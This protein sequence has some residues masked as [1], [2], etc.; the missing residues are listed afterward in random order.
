MVRSSPAGRNPAPR[1]R[2]VVLAALALPGAAAAAPGEGLRMAYFDRYPPLSHLGASGRMEGLLIDLVDAVGARAGLHFSHHG[3]P[4]ARA[5]AMVERGELD[6]LCTN[7]TPARKVYAWF[8]DTP[9]LVVT[10]GLFFR[11]DDPRPRE[12][13]S[14]AEM[15][16]LR[17]GSYRGSGFAQQ[18]LEP[19]RIAFDHDAESVL[20]RIALGDLD[21]YVADDLVTLPQIR[22]LG[23]ATKLDYRPLSFLPPSQYRWGLRKSYPEADVLV[24]RMEAAA[25]QAERDGE[26]RALV[27]RQG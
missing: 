13:R 21:I 17:Q 12:L 22:R 19:E 5:Q 1:R 27:A 9:L 3:Y 11:A 14:V 23:L 24:Q 2:T 8:C 16:A 10:M 18:Y 6:A 25:R 7:A 4:W 15:R 20:R 26:L